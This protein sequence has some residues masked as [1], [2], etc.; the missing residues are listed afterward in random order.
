VCERDKHARIHIMCQSRLH[1]LYPAICLV[2]CVRERDTYIHTC[3]SCADVGCISC[4]RSCYVFGNV[5]V[6]ETNIHAYILCAKAAYIP[7]IRSCDLIGSVCVKET[8]T[9]THTYYV[10]MLV[11]SRVSD[12]AMCLAACV[13][14]THTHTRDTHAQIHITFQNWLHLLY[15]VAT[16]SRRLKMMGPFGKRA[17][18]KSLYSA[19][20]TYNCKEPTNRSHPISDPAIG[21]A[22]CV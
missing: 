1:F 2:V 7:C 19:K 21:L 17:L 18:Q 13:C 22:V 6:R 5:R 12:P 16:I 11:A 20:E 9:Y 8:H 3:I 14:V 15:V 10:P 4:V